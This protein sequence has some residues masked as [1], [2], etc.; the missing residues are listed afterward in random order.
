M[1]NLGV[2]H[3][4]LG[5]RLEAADYYQ[6]AYKLYQSWH[7]ESRAARIQANRGALL[8]EY[9]NPDE[10]ILDVRN[11]LSVSEKTGD[12]NFQTFC[13]RVIATYLRNQ[14]RHKEA[15]DELNRGLAIARERNLAENV[16]V[17]DDLSW[18]CR[19]FRRPTMTPHD[20]RSW[21]H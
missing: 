9:G 8:I 7:D 17:D 5:N 12:R 21:T 2:A 16:T 6:Q 13:L 14:G 18:P 3:A 20:G 1:N 19:S 15:I 10:G 11:A 4:A